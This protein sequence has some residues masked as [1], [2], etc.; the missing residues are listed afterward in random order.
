MPVDPRI[1][2][3]LDGPLT[4]PTDLRFAPMRGHA[5]APGTGPIGEVCRTC[6]HREPTDCT[7]RVWICGAV[8]QHRADRGTAIALFEKAC[9]RWEATRR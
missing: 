2:A 4:T 1:Q 3:I 8:S 9:G 7:Y 6:R 5:S